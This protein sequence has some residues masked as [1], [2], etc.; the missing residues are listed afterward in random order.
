MECRARANLLLVLVVPELLH[1][2]LVVMHYRSRL[3]LPSFGI[4]R[5]LSMVMDTEYRN[6]RMLKG[7]RCVG[8]D[9]SDL[10]S[11]FTFVSSTMCS[12]L[13]HVELCIALQ[14]VIW[15]SI[16]EDLGGFKPELYCSKCSACT[17]R[18]EITCAARRFVAPMW[19]TGRPGAYTVNLYENGKVVV[20]MFF[21]LSRYAN[22]ARHWLAGHKLRHWLWA[23]SAC[24]TR[25][26]SIMRGS[27]SILGIN[28]LRAISFSPT[29]LQQA[30][31]EHS[32]LGPE[33][34]PP[35]MCHT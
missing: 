24:I 10:A 4:L 13:V 9:G 6:T 5:V 31:M 11:S 1:G 17:K 18:Y 32:S 22:Q 23:H 20:R 29:C 33:N 12:Q 19:R 16:Y 3:L 15:N 14:W 34:K 2:K 21:N 26:G 30:F 28:C 27:L 8:Y 7:F 35:V 25:L